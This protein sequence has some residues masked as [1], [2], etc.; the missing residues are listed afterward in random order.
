MIIAVPESK[1]EWQV[2]YEDLSFDALKIVPEPRIYR[3]YIEMS[4]KQTILSMIKEE[5]TD[6]TAS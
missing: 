6:E 4:R 3:N 2:F 1:F 5:R